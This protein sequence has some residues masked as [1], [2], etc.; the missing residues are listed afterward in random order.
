VPLQGPDFEKWLDG[1]DGLGARIAPAKIF[2][3]RSGS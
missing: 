1:I 2:T 3:F